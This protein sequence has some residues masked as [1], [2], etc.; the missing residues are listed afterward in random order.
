MPTHQML[1]IGSTKTND[2]CGGD[3]SIPDGQYGACLPCSFAVT[4]NEVTQCSGHK[5]HTDIVTD[6]QIEKII[7]AV[8]NW[9]R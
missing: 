5:V 6:G 3:P 1:V 7:G 4:D 2:A 8:K 9:G